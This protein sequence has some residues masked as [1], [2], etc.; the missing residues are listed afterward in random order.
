MADPNSEPTQPVPTA[1]GPAEHTAPAPHA[2][3][4]PGPPGPPPPP[5]P[6]RAYWGPNRPRKGPL[7]IVLVGVVGLLLGCLVGGGIGFVVGHV[8]G[9]GH[10]ARFDNRHQMP[11]GPGFRRPFRGP[12]V[13]P[14]PVQPAQ[15]AQPSPTRS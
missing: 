4:P 9:G 6:P 12:G 11:G 5:P 8:S 13:G 14:G 10:H 7:L 3:P 1:D 15:P 2:P